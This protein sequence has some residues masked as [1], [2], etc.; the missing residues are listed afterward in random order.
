MFPPGNGGAFSSYTQ[1]RR[2]PVLGVVTPLIGAFYFARWC[3]RQHATLWTS[4][5]RFDPSVG[6]SF[7][8]TVLVS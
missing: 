1:E 3:N 8:D 6:S 2:L 5:S 7:G 4:Y